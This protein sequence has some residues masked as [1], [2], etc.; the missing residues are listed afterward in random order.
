MTVALSRAELPRIVHAPP[1]AAELALVVHEFNATAHPVPPT[2]AIGPFEAQAAR[3]PDAPA[4]VT[5]RGSLTYGELNARANRV[6]R[7]LISYGAGPGRAVRLALPSVTDT[8]IG[9]LA[10]LKSGGAWVPG[11]APAAV[12]ELRELGPENGYLSIDPPRALTPQH[13]AAVCPR[14]AA[15]VPHSALDHR[16]RWLQSVAPVG[17]GDRVLFLTAGI[18]DVAEALRALRHGAAV[19]TGDAREPARLARTLHQRGVTS[20]H[21][22][23]S[24]LRGLLPHLA[25]TG[26]APPLRQVICTGD[27][28]TREDVRNAARR[29]PDA[30]LHRLFGHAHGTG[31]VTH[32]LC[33]PDALGPVPLGRPAWNTRAYVLDATLSPCPP[34][35]PGELYVTGPH[36]ITASR[37][38]PAS[39][40][41]PDPYGPAGSRLYRTGTR[42]LWT[43]QGEL[44]GVREGEG[45]FRRV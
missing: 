31:A 20:C 10:V 2:T 9:V 3:T 4:L 43:D 6:A 34:G 45:P 5:A 36:L 12:T 39:R 16:V 30:D 27:V 11:P 8:L 21:M 23:P 15:V 44:L 35:V 26:E 40:F 41:A 37:G 19:V 7:R 22:D 42:A 33:R 18:E 17:P 14:T 24:L 28:L 1:T 29:L 38:V 32:H 25:T 13:A